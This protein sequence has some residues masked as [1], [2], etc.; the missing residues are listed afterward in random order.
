MAAESVE[1]VTVVTPFISLDENSDV[2]RCMFATGI[3]ISLQIVAAA[4]FVLSH[5]PGPDRH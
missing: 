3:S 2:L 5:S 4:P 1:T